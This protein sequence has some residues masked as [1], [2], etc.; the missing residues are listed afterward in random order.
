MNNTSDK[1]NFFL[2][3]TTSTKKFFLIKI[4]SSKDRVGDLREKKMS[5][6]KREILVKCERLLS[7][8][9]MTEDE[10]VDVLDSLEKRV[11]DPRYSD[12]STSGICK[13]ISDLSNHRNGSI[14]R[15][16]SE[17]M[18]KWKYGLAKNNP[19]RL[20]AIN[21]IWRA[22]GSEKEYVKLLAFEIERT[23]YL[24]HERTTSKEYRER[25]RELSYNLSCAGSDLLRSDVVNGF[26][27]V[28][29]FCGMTASELAPEYIRENRKKM[30]ERMTDATITQKQVVSD[31]IFVCRK[32]HKNNTVCNQLQTRSGDEGMTVFVECLSCNH[33][34]R[35]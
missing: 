15:R 35:L 4:F 20:A 17:L 19:V 5:D 23:T 22:L 29:A 25:I 21:S 34:W 1:K 2:I 13:K 10:I 33:R 6:T 28:E 31:G 14:S 32:C 24:A 11:T 3:V 18:S 26:T 9:A 16:A 12:L 30:K 8:S 7:K 27:S